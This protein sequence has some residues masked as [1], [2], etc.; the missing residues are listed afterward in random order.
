MSL[1]PVPQLLDYE[2]SYDEKEG[3]YIARYIPDLPDEALAAGCR[4]QIKAAD[5]EAMK[6]GA[7]RNR[8]AIE[9]WRSGQ[10]MK[11]LAARPSAAE[12]PFTAGDEP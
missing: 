4:F 11:R 2:T 10:A 1:R 12:M 5:A 7:I 3:C 9:R 8:I 6:N